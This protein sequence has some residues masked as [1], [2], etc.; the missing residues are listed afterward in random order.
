MDLPGLRP[1]ERAPSLTATVTDRIRDEIIE[2]GLG[3]GAQLSETTLSE[4]L[5]VSRT[6][7][8]EA[9]QLL[10]SERL[11]EVRPQRGTF[12]FTIDEAGVREVWD[13]REV[14][15]VGALRI[16]VRDRARL[17]A[18]LQAELEP[19]DQVALASPA[20]Y[21]PFDHAFHLALF[22][23]AGNGQLAAA[24]GMIDGRIRALRHRF[25]RSF[26]DVEGS[27]RDHRAMVTELAARRPA[28]AEALLRTHLAVS[29]E[30]LIEVVLREAASDGDADTARKE[31][32]G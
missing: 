7:V 26:R 23:A 9:F 4:R 15:E 13:L 22:R 6:P 1:V 25:M 28:R 30:K 24:Y 19:A 5:G 2:G 20:A 3:L 29:R 32:A 27:K 31:K 10:Q 18:L 17:V 11:V 16:A 8:R 21:Q 14:L 12:V